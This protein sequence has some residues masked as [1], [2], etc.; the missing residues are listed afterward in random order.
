MKFGSIMYSLCT[1]SI[2]GNSTFSVVSTPESSSVMLMISTEVYN[3]IQVQQ[4]IDRYEESIY[5]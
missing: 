5:Y 3:A 2:I 4:N 1:F